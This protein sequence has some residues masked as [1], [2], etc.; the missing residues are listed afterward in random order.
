MHEACKLLRERVRGVLGVVSFVFGVSMVRLDYAAL[1]ELLCVS[2]MSVIHVRRALPLVVDVHGG[3]SS[4]M[5]VRVIAHTDVR[6]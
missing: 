4:P 5:D 2:S 3:M 1:C 6:T